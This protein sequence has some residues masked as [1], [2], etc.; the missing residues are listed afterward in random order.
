MGAQGL[1]RGS[2]QAT[3]FGCASGASASPQPS[4]SGPAKEKAARTKFHP[5]YPAKTTLYLSLPPPHIRPSY[6]LHYSSSRSVSRSFTPVFNERRP[7]C[8]SLFSSRSTGCA[9]NV[10]HPNLASR[11]QYPTCSLT[12]QPTCCYQARDSN[13][14]ASRH[15]Y[16][17]HQGD[18]L[19]CQPVTCSESHLLHS[20]RQADPARL[21]VAAGDFK[22][23][24]PPG[25]PRNNSQS[26]LR[27]ATP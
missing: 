18:W 17:S 1:M 15:P 20:R 3:A 2:S 7:L 19:Q 21:L 4:S 10:C 23:S 22:H 27:I 9:S 16:S 5:S 24:S 25:F 14:T 8:P 13:P 11:L 6:S 26:S 12:Y